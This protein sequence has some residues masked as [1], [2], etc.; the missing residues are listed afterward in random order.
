M[1]NFFSE[2]NFFLKNIFFWHL[3]C[4]N[5]FHQFWKS[6]K[7]GRTMTGGG[8]KKTRVFSFLPPPPRPTFWKV[9]TR[10]ILNRFGK[11]KVQSCSRGLLSVFEKKIFKKKLKKIFFFKN[12][13]KKNFFFRKKTFFKFFLRL[14]MLKE[15]HCRK[16]F[17]NRSKKWLSYEHFSKKNFFW[18]FFFS[19][20]EKFFSQ[21]FLLD[22][23]P[24]TFRSPL[25]FKFWKS[26]EKWSNYD[27]GGEERKRPYSWLFGSQAFEYLQMT[28][29]TSRTF[30]HSLSN[31]S[32]FLNCSATNGSFPFSPPPPPS[33]SSPIFRRI[34]KT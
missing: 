28:C 32:L 17:W 5:K 19:R 29:L 2:K 18:N 11:F 7:N 24:Q 27:W 26:V 16:I 6:V 3:F 13:K 14:A 8:E 4:W 25:L 12:F 21:F 1:G 15:D 34:F 33:H 10:P 22:W 23:T 9:I 30:T 20:R 31:K